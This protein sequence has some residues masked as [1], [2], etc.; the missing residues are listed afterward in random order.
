M[1]IVALGQ[2]PPEIRQPDLGRAG[3]VVRPRLP[4]LVEACADRR[5]REVAKQDLDR[6]GLVR[7]GQWS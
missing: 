3:K 7:I 5:L 1:G 6:G 2:V 4:K